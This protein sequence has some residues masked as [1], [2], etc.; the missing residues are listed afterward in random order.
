MALLSI[1]LHESTF[2]LIHQV[3]YFKDV[4]VHKAMWR[5]NVEEIGDMDNWHSWEKKFKWLL[6][7]PLYEASFIFICR[8]LYYEDVEVHMAMWIKHCGK[9]RDTS[10]KWY[11]HLKIMRKKN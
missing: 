1:L 7:N 4:Q 5:K 8:V 10:C 6:S 11:T 3:L 9:N 2:I